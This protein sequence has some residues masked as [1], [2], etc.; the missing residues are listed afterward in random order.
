MK[1]LLLTF[2]RS[3]GLSIC[4]HETCKEP[5]TLG[6]LKTLIKL[7]YLQPNKIELETSSNV[8]IRGSSSTTS[9]Y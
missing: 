7:H 4:E 1:L 5:D 8:E 9:P 2:H 6:C 3:Y